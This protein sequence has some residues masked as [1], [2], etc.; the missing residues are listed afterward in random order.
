[1]RRARHDEKAAQARASEMR[2][3]AEAHG[4]RYEEVVPDELL[5]LPFYLFTMNTGNVVASGDNLLTGEWEDMPV[6]VFDATVAV[7]DGTNIGGFVDYWIEHELITT[8][9]AGTGAN[10]RY[11]Y[12]DKKDLTTRLADDLDK[13]DHLHH[14][15]LEVECGAKDFDHHFEVHTT[16][17]DFARELMSHDMMEALLRHGTGFIYEVSGR[18]FIVHTPRE[19]HHLEELLGATKSFWD[20]IPSEVAEEFASA[21]SDG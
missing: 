16:H 14:D 6:D 8:A 1:M 18:Q 7:P 4:F 19:E 12:I 5:S 11:V 3:W 20:L 21:E 9:M 13:I 15:H 10:L 17:P 2:A